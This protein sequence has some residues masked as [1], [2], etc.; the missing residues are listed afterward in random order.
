ML[1]CWLLIPVLTDPPVTGTPSTQTSLIAIVL[2]V[3][4]GSRWYATAR[5]VKVLAYMHW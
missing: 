1:A 2:W 3:A 4:S 5:N